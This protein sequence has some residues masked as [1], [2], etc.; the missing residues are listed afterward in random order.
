MLATIHVYFSS[1]EL[2]TFSELS[3]RE[4]SLTVRWRSSLRVDGRL[5]SRVTEFC[6]LD[7]ASGSSEQTHGSISLGISKS[8]RTLVLCHFKQCSTSHVSE[9]MIPTV[10]K[11]VP[12]RTF[13]PLATSAVTLGCILSLSAPE[14]KEKKNIVVVI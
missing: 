4:E 3:G 11:S 12:T 8:V 7:S 13:L 10:P 6:W 14:K 9:S 1:S 2:G 5:R